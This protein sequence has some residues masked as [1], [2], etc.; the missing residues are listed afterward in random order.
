[1][2][3]PAHTM[4]LR[5]FHPQIVHHWESSELITLAMDYF[6]KTF[7]Q[8]LDIPAM[9]RRLGV[10]LTV[11][12]YHFDH[13]RG[14]TI[15]EALTHYRL[16]RLCD[17]IS[18]NPTGLLTAQS[19]ACGFASVCEA[20]RAFIANFCLDLVQ[21]RNQ[22]LHVAAWRQSDPQRLRE[23]P[24]ELVPASAPPRGSLRERLTPF[25]TGT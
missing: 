1:V 18:H 19:E 20:N 21:F 11:L 16:N 17:A 10:S 4:A 24:L 12:E 6:A 3:V 22:C 2:D 13:F 25:H 9:A 15:Y 8:P 23:E 5:Q 14:R 7:Q